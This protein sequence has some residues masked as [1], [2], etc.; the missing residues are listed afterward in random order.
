MK[1]KVF[2]FCS[3]LCCFVFAVGS[4]Q[5][6]PNLI[7][8]QGKL[9]DS[10]GT[11]VTSSVD[12]MFTFWNAETDGSQLGGGFSDTDSI[13]PNT[14]GIYST[15]IGDASSNEIPLEVFSGDS[16]YLEVQV[17]GGAGWETLSP[18]KRITSTGFAL[19]SLSA[20][21]ALN[22]VP[23]GFMIVGTT[24]T[25]PTGFSY[26]GVSSESVSESWDSATGMGTA[27]M[28]FTCGVVNGKIYALGGWYNGNALKVV[29]EYDP[30]TDSW[31]T[32]TA[33]PTG[34]FGLTCEVVDGKIYV[35][36]GYNGGPLNVLE[37]YDPATDS[38]STKASMPTARY[39][40]ACGVVNGKIYAIGG[41]GGIRLNVVEEYD[42]AT[43]SWLTKAPM[44]T[45]RNSLACGV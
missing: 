40:F 32:K 9:T 2:I 33:M 44:P 15:L 39:R 35:I 34:R 23:S 43:D 45:T 24:S 14:D 16:V 6:A 42:P 1:Q 20:D 21:T 5:A 41:Y 4:V 26:Y 11:P 12:V 7:N 17:N 29:E 28:N 36:G 19:H 31:E 18:R 8:Y 10:G 27:R 30:A 38:W 22:G 37:E 3:I 25:P 13:T